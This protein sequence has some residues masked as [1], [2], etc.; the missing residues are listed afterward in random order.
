MSQLDFEDFSGG[1]TDYFVGCPLNRY[2][3]AD[4]LLI[5]KYG[6][7][8]RLFTR[9]GSEIWND[10]APQIPAGAQRVGTL[11]YFESTLLVHSARKFYYISGTSFATLQG[12]SSNDVFPSGV[13][14]TDFVSL[15][16]LNKHLLVTNT[17][18]SKPQKI[19]LDG[20]TLKLRTAGLPEP[21]APT[22]TAGAAGAGSYIYRFHFQYTYTVGTLTFV[23]NGPTVEVTLGA[24][25]APNAN[26]VAITVIQALANSTT[27]NYD[28][29][30]A[31]LKVKIARTTNGGQVFY[32]AGSV[33]N[34]TTTFN[35]SMSDAT[36]ILQTPLYTEG[37]FVE[38]DEPPLCKYVHATE[39][40]CYYVHSKSGSE[41]NPKRVHQSIPGDIDGVPGDFYTDVDFDATGI[42]SFK[43][44]PIIGT[45]NGIFRIEGS[46][47]AQGRGGMFS[48]RISDTAS[49]V[50]H[51][52]MVQTP[53]GVF[54]AGLDGFY[55]SDAY[56][57]I[58]VNKGWDKSY[59]DLV[60]SATK[61]LRIYG[62]YN[63]KKN[64][65]Y[66]A[67]DDGAENLD[68][69]TVYV[70]HLD[71]G[72]SDS[73]PFTS[74]S[75]T[76][77]SAAC[78]EVDTEGNLIRGT[79]N[80]YVMAHDDTVYADPRVDTAV[81]ASTW[82]TESI[83][84][85][86]KSAST[87]FGTSAE[88]KWVSNIN[89]V[90]ENETNLSLQIISNNDK[91]LR[92]AELSPIRFRGNL[93]WGDPN[94]IW[95]DP[96]LIWNYSGL[97]S[98]KRRMPSGS[99]RCNYK[100]IEMTNAFVAIFNSDTF[101]TAGV[102]STT[103]VVTLDVGAQNWPSDILDYYIS[104]ASDN[105]QK[106]YIITARTDDTITYSDSS[107]YSETATASAWVIRGYPKNEVLFLISYHVQFEIFG[108][109][110]TPFN[111]GSSG[112]VGA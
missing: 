105:Y 39:D 76:S 98:E 36:L 83:I 21:T 6:N 48:K 85:N 30:S 64:L 23:D 20:S 104:F 15:T 45:L 60:D 8:G 79:K 51:L 103:K 49:C 9:P 35:D 1:I 108:Q 62:K 95:G 69:Q 90:A 106:E 84:Y 59:Q 99:L 70:L 31:N 28:T 24:A 81:A 25:A 97:I 52:S 16:E 3:E 101:G 77:F 89:V 75:G 27:H 41:V 78:L 56:N 42:S 22:V 82:G 55:F 11:K 12:P 53:V 4:N 40:K 5:F 13:A 19:F 17:A 66:W 67:C 96:N 29:A 44:L 72:I 109:T 111:S 34:G 47:D 61:K 7:V 58:K 63:P 33:N 87:N 74:W 102:N 88:R 100:Q 92:R 2:E 94:A 110:Q 71:W 26:A 50:S 57:C 86:Y 65:V 37:G 10:D 32:Y 91:N 80:G 68:N 93:V 46:F 73:M 38:A 14:T 54:W 18:F 43:G 107:N 112:E